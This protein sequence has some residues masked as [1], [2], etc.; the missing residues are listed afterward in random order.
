LRQQFL[1]PDNTD[2]QYGRCSNTRCYAPCLLF[3]AVPVALL[4]LRQIGT[5]PVPKKNEEKLLKQIF[6]FILLV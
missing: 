3:S 2:M 4:A 1:V 5:K 6:V